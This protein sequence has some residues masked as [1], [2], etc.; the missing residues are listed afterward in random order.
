[1]PKKT[2]ESSLG[3]KD[4]ARHALK[5]AKWAPDRMLGTSQLNLSGPLNSPIIAGRETEA[6]GAQ[7]T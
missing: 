2:E 1:M 5:E 7:S 6:Q 4:R 3:R